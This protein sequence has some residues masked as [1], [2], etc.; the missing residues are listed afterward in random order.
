MERKTIVHD[1]SFIHASSIYPFIQPSFIHFFPQNSPVACGWIFLVMDIHGYPCEIHP[2]CTATCFTTGSMRPGSMVPTNW[3]KK[4]PTGDFF[5]ILN[6]TK[7]QSF[8]DFYDFYSTFMTFK[9]CSIICFSALQ[10]MS[11]SQTSHQPASSDHY[12]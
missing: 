9:K 11:A 8:S 1:S 12:S 4:A 2:S 10:V 3:K 7:C 6:V 5:G